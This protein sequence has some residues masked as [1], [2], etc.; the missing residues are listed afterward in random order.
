MV[1]FLKCVGNE[2]VGCIVSR[3][4]VKK[5]GDSLNVQC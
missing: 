4:E 5:L 1:R 3:E 2:T